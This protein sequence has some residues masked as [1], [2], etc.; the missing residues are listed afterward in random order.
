MK[1]PP[2]FKFQIVSNFKDPLTRQLAESVRIERRGQSILNSKSEYSRCCVPRLRV[3]MEEWKS[4]VKEVV[5]VGCEQM[6]GN[7]VDKAKV[8][9]S[10]LE[11]D[12]NKK[13]DES[14]RQESKRKGLPG[15]MKP[16]RRKLEKLVG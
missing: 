5:E 8:M 2:Q 11:E 4:K 7:A 14:R 3:D 15:G 1:E 10:K 6:V 16:K 13:E 9:D 12:R